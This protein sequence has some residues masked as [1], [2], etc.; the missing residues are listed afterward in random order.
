MRTYKEWVESG[1]GSFTNYAKVGDI[2]DE[3]IFD[4]FI[5]TMPPETMNSKMVQMGEAYDHNGTNG[6]ARF[7]TLEKINNQWVYT[8]KKVKAI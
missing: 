7:L 8:G 4:F 3:E 5:E 6:K 1:V 2:V